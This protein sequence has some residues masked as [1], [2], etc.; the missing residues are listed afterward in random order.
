MARTAEKIIKQAQA[1]IGLKESDGTFKIIIDT[2]NAHK[3]LARG[4][5]MPYDGAWCA[6]FVSAVSIACGMT[7]I[8][9]TECSC[10][11]MIEKFKK[12]NAWHENEDYTPKAGDIVFYEWSDN[13]KGDNKE[14]AD[15]VGI[16]E[17]VVD[18]KITVIEGNYSQ[19]VKRRT[20]TKNQKQL[21]GY[22]I[23]KYE[24]EPKPEPKPKIKEV[25]ATKGAQYYNK[26]YHGTYTAT[27]NVYLRNGAG[28]QHKSLTIV[29]KGEKVKC[30]G[31][32]SK[33]LDTVWYYIEFTRDNVKYTGFSSSKYYKK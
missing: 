31:Y 6:T 18:N 33:F 10:E 17:K 13:G 12:L 3:P 9:P 32:Y 4:Y 11:R 14:W 27:G 24:E 20:I 2:Y 26:A 21:R 5:K 28:I 22:A 19:S 25:T 7:D 16:V 1:W 29:R 30:Y 8:I 23:P 15:H